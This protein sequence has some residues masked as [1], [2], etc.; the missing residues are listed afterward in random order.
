MPENSR[1]HRHAWSIFLN[2]D[3]RTILWTN[4]LKLNLSKLIISTLTV[5]GLRLFGGSK[6]GNLRAN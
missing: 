6:S 4:F 3:A 5:Y 2:F 1:L